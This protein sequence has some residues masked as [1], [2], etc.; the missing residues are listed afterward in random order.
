MKKNKVK[1]YF[2]FLVATVRVLY[3][4]MVVGKTKLLLSNCLFCGGIQFE[5]LGN[6]VEGNKCLSTSRCLKCGAINNQ[7]ESWVK[8]E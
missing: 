7:V 2:T 6:K 4:K 1:V 8:G 3:H 5:V